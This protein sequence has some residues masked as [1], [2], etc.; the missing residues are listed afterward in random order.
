MYVI[1]WVLFPKFVISF[2]KHNLIEVHF[3][4]F[5]SRF[6]IN[7]GIK[8]FIHVKNTCSFYIELD[9][10]VSA[11]LKPN[12]MN[13]LIYRFIETCSLQNITSYSTRLWQ[14]SLDVCGFCDAVT[15]CQMTIG[16]LTIFPKVKLV[17]YFSYTNFIYQDKTWGFYHKTFLQT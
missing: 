3:I 16:Q 17:H 11:S 14:L 5:L 12:C 2:L 8:P 7:S 6:S 15:V 13:Y 10:T 9:L 1:F 4:D